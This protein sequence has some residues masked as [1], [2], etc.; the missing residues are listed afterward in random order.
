VSTPRKPARDDYIVLDGVVSAI[1]TGALDSMLEIYGSLTEEISSG[2]EARC[3]ACGDCCRFTDWG[4]ELRLT[5]LELWVLLTLHGAR[6]VEEPGVCPY[7]EHGRC[8]ARDGRALGCRVFFCKASAGFAEQL[9]ERYLT[10]LKNLAAVNDLEL[11][12]G[13]LLESLGRV[14][15]YRAAKPQTKL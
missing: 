10:R 8:A 7:L 1:P 13:E 11:E 6:S 15:G 14:D 4:H 12:Y 2:T 9:Y 5:Q 3:E